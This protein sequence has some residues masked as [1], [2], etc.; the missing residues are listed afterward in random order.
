MTPAAAATAA[1]E[2]ICTLA[3]VIPVLV[4]HDPAMLSH[5]RAL[6]WR[7]DCPRWK[8]HCVPRQQSK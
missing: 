2:N 8:S 7:A 5:W 6:W 3:P 4:V 1:A